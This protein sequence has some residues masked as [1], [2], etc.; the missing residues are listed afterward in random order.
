[1]SSFIPKHPQKFKKSC[2][3]TPYIDTQNK[4][5]RDIVVAQA[6]HSIHQSNQNINIGSNTRFTQ[7]A[8]KVGIILPFASHI[9]RSTQ[10]LAIHNIKNGTATRTMLK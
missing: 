3:T 6:A 8:I 10:V 2:L 9:Q 1:M 5:I 7:P 4:A